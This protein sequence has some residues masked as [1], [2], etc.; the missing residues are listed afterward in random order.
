M[1]KIF[2]KSI[3][4][5][6]ALT[7]LISAFSLYTFAETDG[8]GVQYVYNRTYEEGWDW[9]NG[10]V[11]TTSTSGNKVYVD[12]EVQSDNNY[13]YFMRFEALTES[14][15]TLKFDFTTYYIQRENGTVIKLSLKTDDMA[16][17]AGEPDVMAN[18]LTVRTGM[19]TSGEDLGLLGIKNG[20]LYAYGD[21]SG[22]NATDLGELTDDWMDIAFVFDWDK[23]D[24]V[25]YTVYYGDKYLESKTVTYAYKTLGDIGL[26]ELKIGFPAGNPSYLDSRIGATYCVDNLQIYQNTKEI[27]SNDVVNAAGPGE[28]LD[29]EVP[30]VIE[31]LSSTGKTVDEILEEALCMKLGVDYALER[32]KKVS[33]FESTGEGGKTVYG[34]PAKVNGNVMI[35]LQFLLEYINC[36]FYIHPD[37]MSYDITVGT[38]KTNLVAGRDSASVNGERVPLTTAPGF[39]GTG[40]TKYLAIALEDVEILFPGWLTAYDDMGLIIIYKDTTPDNLDDN[41]DVVNR[42]E[43]LDKMVDLMKK[44]IFSTVTLDENGSAL[45]ADDSYVATGTQLYNDVKANTNNF[46]HPYIGANQS[47]FDKLNLTYRAIVGTANYNA[48]AKNYLTTLVD[49]AEK[50]Y[51]ET[52]SLTEGGAYIGIIPEKVPVNVYKDGIEPDEAN[53]GIAPDTVDGYDAKYGR[54]AE[55]VTFAE[56]LVDLAFAYQVT[57]DTKYVALAYDWAVA[58]GEWEHWG[59][60]YMKDCAEATYSFAVA[61]DWLYNAILEMYGKDGVDTLA[62]IIYEKGVHDGYIAALGRECEHPRNLGDESFYSGLDTHINA[63]GSAGMVAGAL[64]IMSYDSLPGADALASELVYLVGNNIIGLMNNGLYVY[65]PDGSYIESASNWAEGTNSL[66]RLIMALESAAGTDYGLV[67]TWGIDTTCYYAIYIESSDGKIWNY[68]EAPTDGVT[69]GEILGADTQMFNFAAQLFGDST[70]A[71]IRDKQLNSSSA[72]KEVSIYDMLFF[73]FDGI[74]E[75]EELPIDYVIDGLDAFISRSDWEA[76]A[77]YTGIM[78]GAN[79]ANYA[80]LDSGNFI[81]HN[82]GIVW[83]MDL[84][85][86]DPATYQYLG[87]S[88]NNYYRVNPEGQ[89]VVFVTSDTGKLLHGQSDD[90]AGKITKTEMNEH[91][92]FAII[93][94]SSAYR[95]TVVSANRGL[96]VTNDRKTVVIQDEINFGK[97]VQ[98]LVWVAHTA[99]QIE[100]SDDKKMA[101]LTAKD[102]NGKTYTLRASIVSDNRSLQFSVETADTLF[103]PSSTFSSSGSSGLGGAPEYSREGI[104]KLC[105]KLD[106]AVNFKA[107][108]ALEI[109]ESKTSAEPVGYAWSDLSGWTPSAW[110]GAESTG[111]QT[112]RE[113]VNA[114]HIKS[115][116][117]TAKKLFD[118]GVAFTEKLG[119]FYSAL[120]EV[121]YTVVYLEYDFA[122]EYADSYRD[123]LDLYDEYTAFKEALEVVIENSFYFS[124]SFSATNEQTFVADE[125]EE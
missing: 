18:I 26:L 105:I 81:Y 104:K 11:N 42:D 44:F 76:G 14:A 117:K 19:G 97:R 4:L 52:A 120:T 43:H 30:K 48:A 9:D 32:N 86:D 121:E 124:D 99:E 108:V 22:G 123:Y 103:M 91:G 58:L 110:S 109:V 51:D 24:D 47:S 55:I 93:D 3:S 45:R 41:Q 37:G 53:P 94:N 98:S 7:F 74:K 107:A 40:D 102:E 6:L 125:G 82:K 12:K 95:G 28:R 38:G 122:E 10:L 113:G 72:P 59:P 83:F 67:N 79:D 80:Q 57:R 35:P 70:L 34:A 112:I 111:D 27:L 50:F 115:Y 49:K 100:L 54:V 33:I 5:I 101:Y 36:P 13:N 8:S 46:T 88:R 116:T 31:I 63:V 62:R 85:G 66:F 96:M 69:N 77:L 20:H 92:A 119:E 23:G 56:H 60:G 16:N 90:G 87:A 118:D 71:A 89:N 29:T 64:A 21:K 17:F 25:F 84:G 78:G 39:V 114:S 1:K 2:T 106:N 73:P 68:N 15:L 75:A 65:A 61:Y